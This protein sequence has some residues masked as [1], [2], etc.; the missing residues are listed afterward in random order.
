M[1]AHY[2]K[3]GSI[4]FVIISPD[5]SPSGIQVRCAGKKEARAIAKAYH[6]TCWNF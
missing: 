1:Y 6:A 4:H 5:M 2:F 3:T